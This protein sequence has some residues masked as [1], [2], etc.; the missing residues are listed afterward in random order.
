MNAIHAF[1]RFGILALCICAT[2]IG[3]A[4]RAADAQRFDGVTLRVATYGGPWKDGLQALIGA[5]MEKLG[6]KVE[7]TT[8]PPSAHLAK[9][10]AARGK[11]P[12][13]DLME[14]DEPSAPL[15]LRADVLQKYD[16]AKLPN[17]AGLVSPIAKDGRLV[18]DWVF[19]DG[20]VYNADKFKELG[21][22]RPT[23][24]RD[25]LDPKLKGRVG[26][27]DISGNLGLFVVLGFALD[28]GGDEN[29]VTPGIEAMK[30]LNATQFFTGNPAAQ[31]ALVAGD[32]WANFMGAS[33]AV[34]LRRA[35]HAWARFAALKV[36]DKVGIWERG[37]IGLAKGTPNIEAAHYFVNRYISAEV[38]RELSLR[39]GS[40]AVN[41]DALKELDK[42]PLL[43]EVLLLAPEQ[44][45]RMR[46]VD[47][48]TIDI[49]KWREEWNRIMLQ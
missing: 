35:G 43:H 11:A 28:F 4:A 36:G 39:L 31:T 34:R 9:L 27:P 41:K 48:D 44:I 7:F 3:P 14:V 19:E 21:L 5:E 8:G 17:A 2:L 47:F 30:G 38:Q 13:F 12:P 16:T 1:R 24:Y 15:F 25:L 42:D 40:V 18:P 10:I 26:V 46:M 23:R 49:G 32:I 6:A 29:N 22:P 45:D 20:V 33:W 37:Y